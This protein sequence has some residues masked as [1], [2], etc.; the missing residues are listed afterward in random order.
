MLQEILSGLV[1]LS[2]EKNMFFCISKNEK[3]DF[4]KYIYI[5]VN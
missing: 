1:M 5:L 2:I 3:N 4:N